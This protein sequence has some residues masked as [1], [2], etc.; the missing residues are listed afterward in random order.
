MKRKHILLLIIKYKS[1]FTLFINCALAFFMGPRFMLLYIK[2]GH[3]VK[4]KGSMVKLN[5][6]C[7]RH[8]IIRNLSVLTSNAATPGC[9]LHGQDK[10]TPQE[11]TLQNCPCT[12]GLSDFTFR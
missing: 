4:S 1:I 11:G 8:N 3:G 9:Y 10:L 2:G 6:L 12:G 5:I 7:P